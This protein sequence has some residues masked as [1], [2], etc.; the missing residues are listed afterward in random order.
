MAGPDDKWAHR[1]MPWNDETVGRFWAWQSQFPE[2]YFTNLFGDRIVRRL[3]PHLRAEGGEVLDYGCGLGFLPRH[4]ASLGLKV[5]ATDF[6][7][8]AIAKTVERNRNVAGFMGAQTVAELIGQGRTFARIVTV[9]VIEHLDDGHLASFFT[10]LRQLL[11]SGGRVIITTP[12]NENLRASEIYC[13]CCD[14]VFHRYQ[15]VRSF[16]ADT[17]AGAVRDHGFVPEE[18]FT[19]DFSRRPFWHP[20]QIARDILVGLTTGPRPDPHLVC[21]ARP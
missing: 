3:R 10:A 9:E 17:L 16:S 7:P 13:P 11:A 1:P 4:L 14:H 21:I 8:E 19:T 18:V 15:H 2:S 5:W 12:N 6:S 20:R